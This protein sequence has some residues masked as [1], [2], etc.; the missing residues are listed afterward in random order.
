MKPCEDDAIAKDFIAVLA[1]LQVAIR[2]QVDVL[3]AL[4]KSITKQ[5]VTLEES[6]RTLAEV[7]SRNRSRN[8]ERRNKNIP[9]SVNRLFSIMEK[10]A[11]KI[12]QGLSKIYVDTH[13][14]NGFRLCGWHRQNGYFY[15][16]RK[17]A[18]SHEEFM[19]ENGFVRIREQGEW[20]LKNNEI[21]HK[22]L[23]VI[24]KLS[25]IN[26]NDLYQNEKN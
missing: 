23:N 17:V 19:K 7:N 22:V 26:V 21:D 8:I 24:R 6:M 2:L 25:G 11:C 16:P 5:A 18:L 3:A 1:D 15:V 10:N 9:D 12:T 4:E 13:N 20:V 14:G